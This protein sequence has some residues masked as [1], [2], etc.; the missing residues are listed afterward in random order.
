MRPGELQPQNQGEDVL[1]VSW[2]SHVVPVTVHKINV[3][4]LERFQEKDMKMI[5]RSLRASLLDND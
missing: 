5:R 3:G 1:K 2:F 4:E